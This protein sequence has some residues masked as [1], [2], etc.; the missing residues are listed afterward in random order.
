MTYDFDTVLY[1]HGRN[2]FKWDRYRDTDILPFWVADMDFAVAPEIQQTLEERLKHPV[3]GYANAP[4]ELATTI[5]EYLW[6]QYQWPVEE[7]WI[8]WLPG[9]VPGLTVSCQA[10]AEPDEHAITFPPIYHHFLS[11]AQLS[12]K[13]LVEVPLINDAGQYSIDWER[14]EAAI[15]P[16]SRLILLCSPHNPVGKVFTSTELQR[17]IQLAERYESIIVSD[18]IHNG[19]VL[20]QNSTHVPTALASPDYAENIVTLMSP[21]KT[22]NLAGLNCSYAVIPNPVLRRKFTKVARGT[23]PM[24]PAL[25]YEAA[26]AAYRDAGDWHTELLKYL[27]GNYLMLQKAIEKIP[28]VQLTPLEATYLAWLDLS[29]TGLSNPKTYLEQEA[30]IGLSAG[31]EFGTQ[32]KGFVRLNFACPKNTLELGLQRMQDALRST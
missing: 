18:E 13:E 22:F 16:K 7:H 9:V 27:R 31:E 19:L 4:T 32:G 6:Q 12:G 17:L 11:V 1:R 29:G 2:S 20:Q 28:G 24:V 8:V 26:L 15:N 3:Y 5:C 10:F 21:S 23:Q 14:L 30:R 25:A